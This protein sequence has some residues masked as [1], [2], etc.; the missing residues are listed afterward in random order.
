VAFLAA[1]PPVFEPIQPDLFAAGS[2]LVNAQPTTTVTA[3][4]TCSSGS[5]ARP[6]VFIETIA[7]ISI[8]IGAREDLS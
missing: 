1:P 4:S 2:T 7:A 3:T 5:T 6:T 8:S